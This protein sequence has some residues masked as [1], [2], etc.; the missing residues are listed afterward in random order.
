MGEPPFKAERAAVQL[1]IIINFRHAPRSPSEATLPWPEK[2]ALP[3]Y[4][5]AGAAFAF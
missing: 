3:F 5:V 4:F 2:I 1:K